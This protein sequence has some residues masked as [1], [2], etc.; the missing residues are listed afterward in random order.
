[1]LQFTRLHRY[2]HSILTFR[3]LSCFCCDRDS[4]VLVFFAKKNTCA[5]LMVKHNPG[6]LAFLVSLSFTLTWHTS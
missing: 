6:A 5:R 4:N 1:M 2:F 3:S